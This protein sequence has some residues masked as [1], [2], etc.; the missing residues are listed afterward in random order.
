MCCD[1]WDSK[2]EGLNEEVVDCPE[3]GEPAVYNSLWSCY[4][5]TDHCNYSPVKC[6]TCDYAPCDQSC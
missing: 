4:S 2:P 3:C 1:N 6:K 5:A